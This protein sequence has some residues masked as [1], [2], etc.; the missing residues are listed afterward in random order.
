M[1]DVEWLHEGF[2]LALDFLWRGLLA[3]WIID[4]MTTWHAVRTIAQWALL[5]WLRRDGMR[6]IFPLVKIPFSISFPSLSYYCITLLSFCT[7]S[8]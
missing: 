4:C 3:L 1:D 8:M 5:P 2:E 7:L 6:F